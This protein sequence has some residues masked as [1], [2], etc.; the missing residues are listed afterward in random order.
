MHNVR[1]C[2]LFEGVVSRLLL[3]H[4]RC[5]N[6]ESHLHLGHRLLIGLRHGVLYGRAVEVRTI[7]RCRGGATDVGVCNVS[8]WIWKRDL[9]CVIAEVAEAVH[10]YWHTRLHLLLTLLSIDHAC[11]LWRVAGFL[12]NRAIVGGV[13][14]VAIIIL[15]STH[16]V[17]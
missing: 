5:F 11:C 9:H 3:V 13:R 17:A 7:G 16:I 8:H 15:R 2:G 1:E 12:V 10:S 14:H 4:A 6:M